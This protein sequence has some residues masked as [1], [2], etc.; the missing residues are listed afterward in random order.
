M[1]RS[2]N[3]NNWAV[4]IKT[5]VR[6]ERQV[7]IAA[8]PIKNVLKQQPCRKMFACSKVVKNNYRSVNILIVLFKLLEKTI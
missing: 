6:F 8:F 5:I 4:I 2:C 1:Q 7:C 3:N